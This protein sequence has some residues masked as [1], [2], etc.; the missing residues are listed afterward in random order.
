MTISQ[1]TILHIEDETSLANLV[2]STFEHFGFKGEI[3]HVAS[4][5]KALNLLAERERMKA[6]VDLFLLDMHLPDG[7]GLDILQYIKSNPTWLKTPVIILS[8][9]CSQDIINEAYALGANCYLSKLPKQGGGLDHIRSLYQFWIERAL[10]PENSFVS[11]KEEV[12]YKAIQFRARIAKLF[13]ELSKSEIT[14]SKQ[15]SFWLERAIVEGNLSSLLIFCQGLI[16]DIH[17]P[18]ELSERLAKMQS[19]FEMALLR[20]EQVQTNNLSDT[21]KLGVYSSI[22]GML[23][24][25]DEELVAEAFDALIPLNKTVSEALKLRAAK[26]LEEIANYFLTVSDDPALVQRAS[27]LKECSGWPEHSCSKS[28]QQ[29]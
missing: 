12:L 3:L 20:A 15:Q 13:I 2:K 23:E 4:V 21:E 16:R 11:G 27:L 29:N 9:E 7:K 24:A 26:Q 8:G 28:N 18:I 17:I 22:L 5:E 19:R 6:P 1:K 10:V 25:L 14:D